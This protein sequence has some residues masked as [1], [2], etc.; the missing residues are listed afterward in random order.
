MNINYINILLKIALFT[1]IYYH[2]IIYYDENN[3]YNYVFIN[4]I[5]IN[6]IK[7]R[8]YKIKLI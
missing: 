6:K 1:I 4:K 7:L 5:K 2:K 8:I 3:I